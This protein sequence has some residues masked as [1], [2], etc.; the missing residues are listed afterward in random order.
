[1]AVYTTTYRNI[2]N[3]SSS[4]CTA[5]SFMPD[6]KHSS[7]NTTRVINNRSSTTECAN[8]CNNSTVTTSSC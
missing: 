7:N 5:I 8:S 6:N 2:H 4:N 1:M 3:I